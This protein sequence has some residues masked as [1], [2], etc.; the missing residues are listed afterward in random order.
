MTDKNSLI[1]ELYK[2]VQKN[3]ERRRY[4]AFNKSDLCSLDLGDMGALKKHNKGFVFYLVFVNVYTKLIQV[5]TLKKKDAIST[6]KATEKILDRHLKLTKSLNFY[7]LMRE[8]SSKIKPFNQCLIGDRF[9]YIIHSQV[10]MYLCIDFF[11]VIIISQVS[12]RL[13]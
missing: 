10:C 12:N 1:K 4:R 7:W 8:G 6:T 13:S 5:E 9:I 3:F 2:P 11:I